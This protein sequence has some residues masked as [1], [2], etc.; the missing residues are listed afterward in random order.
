MPVRIELA[1]KRSLWARPSM[2][3]RATDARVDGTELVID[4]EP[5]DGSVTPELAGWQI[6][7]MPVALCGADAEPGG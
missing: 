7:E 4:L 1:G 2:T 3:L 5:E 6:V